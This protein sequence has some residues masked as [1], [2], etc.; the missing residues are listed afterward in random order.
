MYPMLLQAYQ[1]THM[2]T[3]TT[4][5]YLMTLIATGMKPDLTGTMLLLVTP[6]IIQDTMIVTMKWNYFL[7]QVS[8]SLNH[9]TMAWNILMHSRISSIKS[10]MTMVITLWMYHIM[11][12]SYQETSSSTQILG[13]LLH[14]ITLYNK[15][16]L[17]TIT[18]LTTHPCILL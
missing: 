15:C 5:Q 18:Y 8:V 9:C 12:K 2:T 17:L 7:T 1:P 4:D 13:M 6:L 10:S 3:V 14:K 16:L 11:S